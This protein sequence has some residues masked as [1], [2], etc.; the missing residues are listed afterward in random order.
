MY[1]SHVFD[2]EIIHGPT[3]RTASECI[4]TSIHVAD[5][6]LGQRWMGQRV[7]QRLAYWDE[8]VVYALATPIVASIDTNGS[9]LST[10]SG[11]SVL[12]EIRGR[13]DADFGYRTPPNSKHGVRAETGSEPTLSLHTIMI[14]TRTLHDVGESIRTRCIPGL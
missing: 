3:T 6:D 2:A 8:R 11:Q 9:G 4:Q 13:G 10:P 7:V 5:P 14:C 12:V 1:D